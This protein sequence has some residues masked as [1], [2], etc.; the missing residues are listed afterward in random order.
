MPSTVQRHPTP[1][2]KAAHLCTE[3]CHLLVL[4]AALLQASC[5][6]SVCR[7]NERLTGAVFCGQGADSVAAVAYDVEALSVWHF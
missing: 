6:L 1:A 3:L 4:P 5:L 7:Y 2:C